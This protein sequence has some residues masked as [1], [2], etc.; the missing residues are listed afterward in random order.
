MSKVLVAPLVIAVASVLQHKNENC[1]LFATHDN[2]GLNHRWP[3]G[4]TPFE[5]LC[6]GR[7]SVSAQELYTRSHASHI[8]SCCNPLNQIE[9]HEQSRVLAVDLTTRTVVDRNLEEH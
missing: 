7:H 2:W 9:E 3:C 6:R 4:A 8:S 1:V 5:C